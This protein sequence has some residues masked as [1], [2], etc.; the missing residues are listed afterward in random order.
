LNRNAFRE[1]P[2]VHYYTGRDIR[3][4]Q[5]PLTGRLESGDP[6][7]FSLDAPSISGAVL[8]NAGQWHDLEKKRGDRYETKIRPDS[9]VLK[10]SVQFPETPDEYWPVL[11]Y[12]VN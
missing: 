8:L 11:I 5:A 4:D 9:G 3:V 1:F 10:L 12:S 6:Y 7:T 2:K